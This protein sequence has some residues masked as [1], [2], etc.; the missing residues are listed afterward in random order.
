[1]GTSLQKVNVMSTESAIFCDMMPKNGRHQGTVQR[2]ANFHD[3]V[4][5]Q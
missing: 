5:G 2:N 1:M 3:L 4:M